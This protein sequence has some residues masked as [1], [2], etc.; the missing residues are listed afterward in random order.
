MLLSAF[1]QCDL[2]RIKSRKFILGHAKES[3]EYVPRH[4]SER[5]R[6]ASHRNAL[7]IKAIR[8]RENARVA[9]LRIRTGRQVVSSPASF[10]RSDVSAS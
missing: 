1:S 2:L 6:R 9:G 7:T 5:R 8:R 4:F 10:T 3:V